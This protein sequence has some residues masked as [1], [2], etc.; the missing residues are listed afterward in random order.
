MEDSQFQKILERFGLS[1]AGYRRVK[2]G[3]KRRLSRHMQELGCQHIEEYIKAVDGNPA[4]RL[5]FECHMTVSISRFFRD[6]GLWKKLEDQLFPIRF[7]RRVN[8]ITP[9]SCRDPGYP[10]ERNPLIP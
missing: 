5:Q 8:Q 10:A 1:W 9:L 6:R 7:A 3:V 4:V 2:K